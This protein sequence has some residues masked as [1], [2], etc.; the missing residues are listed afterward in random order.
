MALSHGSLTSRKGNSE[1]SCGFYTSKQ[2]IKLNEDQGSF[3]SSWWLGKSWPSQAIAQRPAGWWYSQKAT[4]PSSLQ[5]ARSPGS[6][7]FQAT[8]L[9]SWEWAWRRWAVRE[10]VGCCGSEPGSS[11]NTRMA[12]SPH[13]VARAPVSWHLGGTHVRGKQMTPASPT[14]QIREQCF[15][16]FESQAYLLPKPKASAKCSQESFPKPSHQQRPSQASGVPTW[17]PQLQRPNHTF[18]TWRK[19]L[20]MSL[21]P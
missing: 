4:S 17:L 21:H 18:S 16:V 13:A 11:S 12:S 15:T 20:P 1:W 6:L 10:K 2:G 19:Q 3:R 7:G 14:R 8:Q 5:E 9:T